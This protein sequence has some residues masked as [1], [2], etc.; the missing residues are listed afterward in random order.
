MRKKKTVPDQQL[1]EAIGDAHGLEF[2]QQPTLIKL[3]DL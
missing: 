2:H 1:D 3:K